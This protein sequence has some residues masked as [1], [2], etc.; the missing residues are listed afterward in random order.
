[1]GSSEPCNDFHDY[2]C[3]K[4]SGDKELASTELKK[5]AVADLVGLLENATVPATRPPTAVDKLIRAYKSCA[6]S[7]ESKETLQAGIK[8]ILRLYRLGNW[9]VLKQRHQESFQDVLK[10]TGLRPVFSYF[11]SDYHNS[12]SAIVMTAPDDFYVS[13]IDYADYGGNTIAGDVA[14]DYS[15]QQAKFED[16][17]KIFIL[18]TIDLLRGASVSQQ[19][20]AQV[21][22]DIITF[23]KNLSKFAASAEK[24][25]QEMNLKRFSRSIGK[26]FSMTEALHKDFEGL[27]VNITERTK[28]FVEYLQYYKKAVDFIENQANIATLKNY[29]LWTKIRSMALAEGTLLHK[30]YLDYSRNT[31]IEGI[32]ENEGK[33]E[34]SKF[35]CVYQLLN[36]HVMY[37]ASASFY[38]KAN[39]DEESKKGVLKIMEFVKSAFR[40]IIKRNGW[41][42]QHTKTR[43]LQRVK[44]MTT[45][46]GYPDWMMNTSTLNA[47]YKFVPKIRANESFVK[48]F[49]Y[50]KEND[51]KQQLLKLT[52]TY[53][54]K[55]F[56]DA[57]LRSHAYYDEPTETLVYPAAALATHYRKFP[58]PRSLNFGSIG[59]ILGQLLTNV[60]DRFDYE[61][62]GGKRVTVDFWN[63]TTKE[64][65]C[66]SSFC[67]NNT[68][69]CNDEQT[70][71]SNHAHLRDYFGVR[72]AFMALRRS[73]SNY[74]APFLLPGDKF[75]TEQKIFFISF[76]NLYCPY[77]VNEKFIQARAD[78]S[79]DLYRKTLNEVVYGY[80]EFNESFGCEQNEKA[81][82]CQLMPTGE[83]SINNQAY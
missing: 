10:M 63:D 30:I 76:G 72:S 59:T 20:A 61:Y 13:G 70:S 4:W 83:T 18:K 27:G 25:R 33:I 54:N 67:L 6:S 37:S 19:K 3:G 16:A 73:K 51:H 34:D 2:V 32:S 75:D 40:Y 57:P 77:S 60:I 56:E 80:K 48:H 47:L 58:I 65:F 36:H 42:S 55:E 64:K 74:S 31:S 23:E 50:L 68:E 45:I 53:I 14:F 24:S 44:K 38:S 69:E 5:K 79:A 26:N 43:A 17:Y 82:T 28:V 52:K 1:M 81:D 62:Q 21:A 12:P 41:M 15:D 35:A 66:N 71:S 49:F 11:V 78:E 7:G 39:F 22:D 46:I 29:V 9:P 8:N